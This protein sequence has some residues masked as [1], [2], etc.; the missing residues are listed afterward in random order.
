MNK[1]DQQL[2]QILR[3]RAQFLRDSLFCKTP[4]LLEEAAGEIE[5]LKALLTSGGILDQQAQIDALHETRL[6][7]IKTIDSLTTQRDSAEIENSELRAEIVRLQADVTEIPTIC[8][9]YEKRLKE[10]GEALE[11]LFEESEP[12]HCP[13]S[14]ECFSSGRCGRG[15]FE[16]PLENAAGG[17]WFRECSCMSE[18]QQNAASLLDSL[19]RKHGNTDGGCRRRGMIDRVQEG[20]NDGG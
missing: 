9:R 20:G 14:G 15:A 4:A 18:A 6:E 12:S 3:G 17:S 16:T 7:H 10:L 19:E 1:E 5:R 13:F 8:R 11:D 2:P